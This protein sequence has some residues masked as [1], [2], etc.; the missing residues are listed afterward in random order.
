MKIE[1][2]NSIGQTLYVSTIG[3]HSKIN[4]KKMP[5]GIYLLKAHSEKGTVLKKIVKQ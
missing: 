5:L 4:I 3:K 2:Q 1:L